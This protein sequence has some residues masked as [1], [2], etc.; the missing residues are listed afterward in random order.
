[1]YTTFLKLMEWKI[2]FVMNIYNSAKQQITPTQ[3]NIKLLA[4]F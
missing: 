3:L 1:M 2:G 4:D